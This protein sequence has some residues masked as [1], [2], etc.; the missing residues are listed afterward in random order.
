MFGIDPRRIDASDDSVI[1]G[2]KNRLLGILVMGFLPEH[3]AHEHERN[4]PARKDAESNQQV[5]DS[6]FWSDWVALRANYRWR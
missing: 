1:F 5:H 2:V 6:P 4:E 3:D